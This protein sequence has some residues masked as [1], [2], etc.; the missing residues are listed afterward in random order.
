MLHLT[1]KLGGY[2]IGRSTES[3]PFCG[4][5]VGIIESKRLDSHTYGLEQRRTGL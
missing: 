5:V 4:H 2:R 3:L 1:E